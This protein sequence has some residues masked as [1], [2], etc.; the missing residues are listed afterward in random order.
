[1][2]DFT[3]AYAVTA[4]H[5]GGYANNRL[6][7]GGETMLGV[8]RN[9]FP[10]WEGWRIIDDLRYKPGFPTTANVNPELKRLATA[11]Y[12]QNFWDVFRLDAVSSQEIAAEVFDTAVNMGT[13]RAAQFLQRAINVTN[14]GG[15]YAPDIQPDGKVGP[16]TVGALN[17]HKRP[18][19]VLKVLRI[20]R[21]EFYVRLAERSPSQEVFVESWLSRVSL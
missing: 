5:E 18:A 9:N 20:L 15:Q 14:K 19:M 3:K 13:A 2:A 16:A 8:S 21:G 4:R 11:F 6:D 10:K 12:K 1:M 7:T 17:Q